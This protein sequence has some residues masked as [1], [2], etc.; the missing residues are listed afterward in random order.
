MA[1]EESF[2]I[3]DRR[4]RDAAADPAP[5]PPRAEPAPPLSAPH[6]TSTA[7]PARGQESTDADLSNLFV[8][9]ASSA[10][11]ALGEAQDPMSGERGVDLPQAREAIDILLLLRAKTEGNRSEHESQLLEE[12]LY[13]LQVRYVRAAKGGP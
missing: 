10:L 4:H 12:M 3:T 1:E 13:D 2:K 8:M 9:F 11:I 7:S 6:P 5:P